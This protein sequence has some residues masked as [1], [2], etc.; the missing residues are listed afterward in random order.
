MRRSDG[1][2]ADSVGRFSW[3]SSSSV[4]V[5]QVLQQ[6]RGELYGVGLDLAH[7]RRVSSPPLTPSSIIDNGY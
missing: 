2:L 7:L 3:R 1:S 6:E 5:E 4:A